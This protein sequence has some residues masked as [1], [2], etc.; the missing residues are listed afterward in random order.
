LAAGF[1]H[2][3]PFE[4]LRL[5]LAGLA[6]N[7]L[8]R[9]AERGIFANDGD[10]LRLDQITKP[11]LQRSTNA[12][13][14][15]SGNFRAGGLKNHSEKASAKI[16]AIHAFSRRRKQNLFDQVAHMVF[17]RCARGAPVEIEVKWKIYVPHAHVPVTR[18]CVETTIK[19]VPVGAQIAWLS[20][21]SNG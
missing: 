1:S 10:I 2:A 17:H 6:K 21:S 18:V 12:E 14:Q 8:N 3:A 7:V 19:G 9:H 4:R 13:L 16:G 20:K 11:A 5:T 15:S